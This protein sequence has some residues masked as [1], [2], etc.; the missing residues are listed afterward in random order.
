MSKFDDIKG[1]A[2]DFIKENNLNGALN[3]LKLYVKN[4]GQLD[5]SNFTIFHDIANEFIKN[6]KQIQVSMYS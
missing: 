3:I 5:K 6:D 1:Q 2:T 4:G